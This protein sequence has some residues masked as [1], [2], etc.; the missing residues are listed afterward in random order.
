MEHVKGRV[1]DGDEVLA[2]V[3]EITVEASKSRAGGKGSYGCFIVTEPWPPDLRGPLRLEFEDG[4]SGEILVRKIKYST[5][6][7]EQ[8]TI[9]F[10]GTGTLS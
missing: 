2:E 6:S 4:R 3:V 8:T 1:L 9:L 7:S 10:D 5:P